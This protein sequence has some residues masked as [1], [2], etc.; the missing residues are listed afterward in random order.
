MRAAWLRNLDVWVAAVLL[1]GASVGCDVVTKTYSTASVARRCG[2]YDR[3]LLPSIVPSDASGLRV[4]HDT[5]SNDVWVRLHLSRT[6][7]KRRFSSNVNVTGWNQVRK[8]VRRPPFGFG[9][10]HPVLGQHLWHTPESTSTY[11][12]LYEGVT[13]HGVYV[14]SSGM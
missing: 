8:G 2:A 10:W 11:F 12:V 3:G 1:A 4:A 14:P 9:D 6:S 7:W 5:D 13:W